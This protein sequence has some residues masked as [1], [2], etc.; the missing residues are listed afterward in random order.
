MKTMCFHCQR[1][2]KSEQI[3]P[4]CRILFHWKF[5]CLLKWLEGYLFFNMVV[6]AF[7]EFYKILRKMKMFKQ[8]NELSIVFAP[9]PPTIARYFS[10]QKTFN[11]Y[12]N[13][14]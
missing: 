1:K 9:S 3:W 13:A 5:L 14:H 12:A 2:K 11:N 10:C 8:C 6:N 7:I 4:D